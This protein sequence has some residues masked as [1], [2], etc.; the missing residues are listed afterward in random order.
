MGET[1]APVEKSWPAIQR[2]AAALLIKNTLA[3]DDLD[4]LIADKAR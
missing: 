3:H 1:T 2:V 4:A